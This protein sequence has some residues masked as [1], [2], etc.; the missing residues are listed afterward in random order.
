VSRLLAVCEALS[1]MLIIVIAL[2]TYL[3]KLNGPHN[4][5]AKG[6]PADKGG[7]SQQKLPPD[8]GS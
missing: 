8:L 7:A 1:G 5:E 4:A 2:A 3:T 6:Q